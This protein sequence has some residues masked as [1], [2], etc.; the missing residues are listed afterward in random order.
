MKRWALIVLAAGLTGACA[1]VSAVRVRSN[2]FETKGMRYYLPAPYLAITAPIEISRTETILVSNPPYHEFVQLCEKGAGSDCKEAPGNETRS[3]IDSRG[4]IADGR[5]VG[6]ASVK[7][8][9]TSET[10]KGASGGSKKGTAKPVDPTEPVPPKKE[11]GTLELLDKPDPTA[12][13]EDSKP[14]NDEQSNSPASSE[15]ALSIVWLPDTC[16]ELAVSV[17]NRL[18][19]TKSAFTFGDGWK[20]TQVNEESD[21]TEVMGK[22]IDLAGTWIGATK[23]V[24]IAKLKESEPASPESTNPEA[25]SGT[26]NGDLKPVFIT[27]TTIQRLMPGVYPLFDYPSGCDVPAVFTS[28]ALKGAT[29]LQTIYSKSRSEP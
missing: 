16:R 13:A 21:T 10:Y 14:K 5:E 29:V 24:R 6:R 22:I 19:K 2:D 17:K 9:S 7:S 15:A 12:P 28:P 23:E 25:Q 26:A 20:L 4:T 27:R 18:A 11:D 3:G 1:E 8:P